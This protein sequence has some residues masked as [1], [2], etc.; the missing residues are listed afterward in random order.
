MN[1]IVIEAKGLSKHYGPTKAVDAVTFDVAAGEIFG[2]LGPNGAGK[3]TT[4]LMLLGLSDITA[5]SARV[6]GHDPM[7]EP[8]AVKRRVGY[9]PD[10][11]G[12][13]DHLTAAENLRYTARLMGL[14]TAARESKVRKALERVGLGE[15]AGKKVSTFSRGM[16]QRLGLAEIVMKDAR[17]AI[18]DEPTNGLDPQASVELLELI[19][20]FKVQGVSILL[21]SHLLDRVQSVCDRVALFNA[22]RIVLMGSVADLGRQVLGGGYAVEVEAQGGIGIAQRLSTLPGVR[23]VQELAPGR[24]RLTCDRDLRAEAAAEVVAAA[25]RLTQL[26]L[27]HPSLET[28]YTRYFQNLQEV[29]HAA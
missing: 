8:L 27:E 5:G 15:V 24:W 10:S 2:L 19:R 13:Y 17:A 28:I 16:R 11:V 6:F 3:T 1:E 9:L 4:I 12:F 23:T 26:S 21:S 29:P 18:L 20:S 14:P 22:G 25:G 7:R